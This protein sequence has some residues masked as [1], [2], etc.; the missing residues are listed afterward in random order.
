[1]D[2]IE[3]EFAQPLIS[4]VRKGRKNNNTLNLRIGRA[5]ET[6]AR[7]SRRSPEVMVKISGFTKGAG[8][9]KAHMNYISRNGKV[10]V[11][12]QYGSVFR[13]KED[14]EDLWASWDE[15]ISQGNKEKAN[16]RDTVKII[17]SMPPGTDP[18]ALK[19]AVRKFAAAEFEHH[20]YLFAM[21]TDEKHPHVHLTVQMRGFNG[22]RLNP[23][24]ADLQ[25]W[26]ETFADRLLKEGIDCVATPRTSR[27]KARG[28]K[29]YKK[30]AED[31]EKQSQ[32]E[33]GAKTEAQGAEA[34]SPTADGRLDERFKAGVKRTQAEWEAV[35]ERS[36]KMVLAAWLRVARAMDSGVDRFEMPKPKYERYE[37]YE[38]GKRKLR[39]AAALYQPGSGHVGRVRKAGAVLSVRDVS[40]GEVVRHRRSPE[41]LLQGVS[42]D[43]LG[44]QPEAHQDMRRE[45][46]LVGPNGTRKD[47]VN[48]EKVKC[49]P[50]E[51]SASKQEI[52]RSVRVCAETL[53]SQQKKMEKGIEL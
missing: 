52:A 31:W 39:R 8:H 40:S 44:R 22:E 1:M 47:G 4:G 29:Q 41:G 30:H 51:I 38:D 2:L 24:K 49:K 7:V 28:H 27:N 53:Q 20:A 45:R 3:Q 16:R 25:R 18:D 5:R 50:H 33:R 43:R 46:D 19:A 6:A 34:G 13:G 11:E 35:R 12:D 48:L 26:R 23:R 17:L 42:R 36:R 10:D 32:Q 15:E 21:H 14:V 9:L 37:H